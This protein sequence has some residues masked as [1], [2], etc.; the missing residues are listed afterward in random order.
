MPGSGLGAK[1]IVLNKIKS[2]PLWRLVFLTEALWDW[3]LFLSFI[4]FFPSFLI[5]WMLLR[6][7]EEMA[8]WLSLHLSSLLLGCGWLKKTLFILHV[9]GAETHVGRN[10]VVQCCLWRMVNWIQGFSTRETISATCI[11]MFPDQDFINDVD[12]LIFIC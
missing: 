1:N 10:E 7:E 4:H 5:L 2:L 9:Q 8:R 11:S 12:I 3:R 6:F